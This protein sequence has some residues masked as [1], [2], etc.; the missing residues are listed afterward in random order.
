M[1]SI[2]GKE[3]ISVCND[4][5]SSEIQFMPNG[6]EIFSSHPGTRSFCLIT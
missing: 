2:S 3:T 6:Y 5:A 1:H 4:W